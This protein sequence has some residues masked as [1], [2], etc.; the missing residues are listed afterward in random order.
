MSTKLVEIE[1]LGQVKLVKRKNQRN[2]RLSISS[3]QVRVSMPY[4]TPF[5]VG[6]MFARS[7]ADWAKQN[8]QD[9]EHITDGMHIGKSYQLQ[10][11][12]GDQNKSRLKPGVVEA[13]GSPE[14]IRK[15]ILRAL[16]K[17]SEALL[18]KRVEQI[19]SQTGLSYTSL[20]FKHLKSRWGSCSCKRELTFNSLLVQ[21]PWNLIDYVI[22]HE[23]CHTVHMN[24]S[25][26]FWS[27]V[28]AHMPDYKS[29][30]KELRSRQP[31]I[32]NTTYSPA[33]PSQA[34]T[35]GLH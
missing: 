30:R 34:H 35:D 21:M 10:I 26:E 16:K 15:S 8:I 7:K 32:Y 13:S 18:T 23:L 2:L 25:T 19:A 28:E 12:P 3:R 29:R 24:H 33:T 14:H 11:L 22:V 17:E 6:E 4:Y 9:A 1:G 5:K 20:H 27:L 31:I